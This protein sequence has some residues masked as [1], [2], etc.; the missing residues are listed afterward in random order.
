MIQIHQKSL[1]TRRS[2]AL[3]Y[4][5]IV[6]RI[7]VLCFVITLTV[8]AWMIGNA[9]LSLDS[10][11]TVSKIIYAVSVT[12]ACCLTAKK[13]RSGKALWSIVTAA[14]FFAAVFIASALIKGERPDAGLLA[15]ISTI[16]AGVGCVIGTKRRQFG[17]R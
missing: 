9:T 12:V 3:G 15:L 6:V 13:A 1:R 17:Y 7:P 16:A 8:A 14:G 5:L 10:A 2:C 11:S 4:C